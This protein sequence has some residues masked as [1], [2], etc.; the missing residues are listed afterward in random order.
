MFDDFLRNCKPE[1][2]IKPSKK[3]IGKNVAALRS[4]LAKE[5]NS[6]TKH[7]FGHKPLIIAMAV[8]AGLSII[9]GAAVI[10]H[11]NGF[12]FDKG[13]QPGLDYYVMIT[14]NAA[15]APQTIEKICY[16][17]NLPSNFKKFDSYYGGQNGEHQEAVETY[18]DSE[19]KSILT[20]LQ[21]TKNFFTYPVIVGEDV[22]EPAEIRGCKGFTIVHT[23][24]RGDNGKYISNDVIWDCG[25]Y[26]HT[27]VGDN[28][29]ME[30]VMAIVNGMT[31]K[32]DISE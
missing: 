13:H 24:D 2:E 27:V 12:Y 20:I 4:L 16:D 18:Y 9:T 32:Q 31:E 10:I 23:E 11:E 7:K 5:D 6:M 25:D 1:N 30:E 29:P 28:I 15:D 17:Y 21:S 19:N 14:E 8:I 26:I 3:R 22:W